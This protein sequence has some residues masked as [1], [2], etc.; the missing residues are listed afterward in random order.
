[1]R[2]SGGGE[3]MGIDPDLSVVKGLLWSSPP[4]GLAEV[5]EYIVTT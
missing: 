2:W 5:S 1:M 4:A 3:M